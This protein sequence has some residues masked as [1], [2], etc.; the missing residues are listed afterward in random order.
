MTED[1]DNA[2]REY[3]EALKIN[4]D[5]D[6]AHNGLGLVLTKRKAYKE[7]IAEF[8]MA[9]KLNKAADYYNNLGCAYAE[10]GKGSA[11]AL[12]R[13]LNARTNIRKATLEKGKREKWRTVLFYVQQEKNAYV[14]A[15]K[16]LT[17]VGELLNKELKISLFRIFVILFVSAWSLFALSINLE[18]SKGNLLKIILIL[19]GV[20]TLGI[21]L[22][23]L[24]FTKIRIKS[25]GIPGVV[26]VEF[27]YEKPKAGEMAVQFDEVRKP[28]AT[29]QCDNP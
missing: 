9:L 4:K 7:A 5:I 26:E 13:F 17:R 12:C 11:I 23:N 2:E 14:K 20:V 27:D 19:T 8:K 3:R 6:Y 29:V 15:H 24:D 18:L 21:V 10:Y 25:L 22:F 1:Y 28:E 16:N